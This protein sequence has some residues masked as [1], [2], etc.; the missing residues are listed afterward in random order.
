MGALLTPS[1]VK[2]FRERPCIAPTGFEFFDIVE[3]RPVIVNSTS[4]LSRFLQRYHSEDH[5][6]IFPTVRR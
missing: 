3:K 1:R 4:R 5:V 2:K 6:G